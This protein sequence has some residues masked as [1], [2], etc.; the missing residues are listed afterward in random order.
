MQYEPTTT[1][2]STVGTYRFTCVV[3]LVAL[4]GSCLTCGRAVEAATDSRPNVIVL[5]TDDQPRSQFNF[6]SQ[7]DGAHGAVKNLSPNIDRLAAEG[8]VLDDFYVPSTLCVP[9]RYCLLTGT[10]ASRCREASFLRQVNEE[11]QTR[12]IQNTRIQPDVANIASVLR[13]HGYY[14]GIAGKNGVFLAPTGV[15][16]RRKKAD[17]RDPL[18]AREL[19]EFVES[20]RQVLH[21]SGFDHAE[22]IYPG[23]LRNCLPEA[24][25]CHNLDWT[26]Y[27]AMQVIEKAS[28]QEK[29]FF[30]YYPA[31]LDHAPGGPRKYAA[32][33]LAT[34]VGFLDRP[35]Q[36]M[37]ARSSIP[38]RLR[39]GGFDPQ[40]EAGNVLWLDDAIGALVAQLKSSG[41]YENTVILYFTDNGM[42]G[43]KGSLYQN[44]VNVPALVW[45]KRFAG[46]RRCDRLV[47][48]VDVMP[49]LLELCGIPR[50][51]WPKTDGISFLPLLQGKAAKTRETVYLEMGCLRGIVKGDFKYIAFRP[52]KI[53]R[54]RFGNRPVPQLGEPNAAARNVPVRYARH[55]YATDQ[56]FNVRDDPQE[57]ENLAS[58]PRYAAVLQDLRAELTKYLESLPG[59]FGELEP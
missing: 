10:Y 34:A 23:N 19:R 21:E 3:L 58:N 29:P 38:Q 54:Q 33:P 49:T 37:P 32:D 30:L 44:G 57:R 26:T 43:G 46:G 14:T 47:S 51:D 56:L 22:T 50:T 25:Q 35:L 24:L 1:A 12:V 9:S 42:D 55:Y 13:S 48:S 39:D 17:P 5:F 18:V 31:T 59:S 7:G 28:E 6:A 20:H 36:V 53:L 15:H 40:S 52:P 27:G 45:S 4:Y 41:Q 2:N 8:I 16:F 11:K